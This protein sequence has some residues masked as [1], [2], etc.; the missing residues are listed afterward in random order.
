MACSLAVCASPSAALASPCS[1]CI[2]PPC[3]WSACRATDATMAAVHQ[4]AEENQPPLGRMAQPQDPQSP[5]SCAPPYYSLN[6]GLFDSSEHWSYRDLQRLAK[7]L[8]IPANGPRS[9]LAERL[10]DWH[11][12]Q[13]RMD[14]TGKFLCVE[15]RSSPGGQPIS[16]RLLSP[17]VASPSPA[18]SSII[19]SR[20]RAERS[21]LKPRTSGVCFSPVR[22]TAACAPYTLLKGPSFWR[23]GYV[24]RSYTGTLFRFNMVKVIPPKEHTEMFGQYKEPSWD[25]CFDEDIDMDDVE[26]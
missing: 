26:E 19:S 18:P 6:P 12:D 21:P 24:S 25:D 22:H 17:L 5:P 16:P 2:A 10:Q 11:R 23:I 13:R 20:E 9:G 1:Q 14:Q 3:A 4:H 8:G 15:V 7:K